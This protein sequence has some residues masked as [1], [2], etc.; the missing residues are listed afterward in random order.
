[1]SSLPAPNTRNRWADLWAMG[2]S[3]ICVLHCLALPFL[4]ASLPVLSVLSD[5]EWVH[6]A[7]VLLAFPLSLWAV[8]KA[9]GWLNGVR[10]L[11]FVV[12]IGLLGAAA[13]YEPLAAHETVVSV[14]GACLLALMHGL[15]LMQHKH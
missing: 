1:M 15:N 10:F 9:V 5:S 7:L 3:G 12:G 4:M 11:L 6:R 8:I 2:L 14:V 13:F